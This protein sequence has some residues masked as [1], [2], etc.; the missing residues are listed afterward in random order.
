MCLASTCHHGPRIHIFNTKASIKNQNYKRQVSK[1]SRGMAKSGR[2][3]YDKFDDPKTLS[4]NSE[5]KYTDTQIQSYVSSTGTWTKLTF[6]SQG[7]TSITR[8]ADRIFLAKVEMIGSVFTLGTQDTC[9]VIIL[10]TKGLFTTPPATTD[11]LAAVSPLSHYAYN[12]RDLYEIL[13]DDLLSISPNG[14]SAINVIRSA[15]K[16]KIKNI[17]FVPGSVNPYDGQVYVLTLCS[18]SANI[19]HTLNLRLWYEDGN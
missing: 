12:A 11:V 1:H 17:K 5:L 6:P 19:S 15:V 10:Q 2:V 16:L 14:D 8:V 4:I 9:R 7:V 13:F 3:S 18:T